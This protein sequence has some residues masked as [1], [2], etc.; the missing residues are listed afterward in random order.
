[1]KKLTICL[2]ILSNFANAQIKFELGDSSNSIS[3]GTAEP[4]QEVA[5]T[6]SSANFQISELVNYLE[7]SRD[8]SASF[9]QSSYE[10]GKP[11]TR[12]GS[13]AVKKPNKF[14]LDYPKEQKIVCDGK[15]VWNYDLGLEQVSKHQRQEMIGNE[16]M[17]ILGG[18]SRVSDLFDISP[19]TKIPNAMKTAG[20]KVFRLTPKAINAEGSQYEQIF[21]SMLNGEIHSIGVDAGGANKLSV[22]RLMNIK[23]NAGITDNKFKFTPPK[24]VDVIE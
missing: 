16:A 1:M 11:Q 13:L 3:L 17:E 6:N 10:N 22:L 4:K 12:K 9:V 19:A 15:V 2:F 20:A 21:I 8:I 14:L 7:Q 23:R 24:G 5:F 18:S